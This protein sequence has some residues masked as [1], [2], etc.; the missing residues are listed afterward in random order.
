MT[1]L[2]YKERARLRREQD[3]LKTAARM[4]RDHG[5][6]NLNMDELAEEVG[7]SKPTLY[8][9]FKGKDDMVARTMLQTLRELEA[10][11]GRVPGGHAIDKLDAVMR[12]MMASHTDPE[13]LSIAIVRDGSMMLQHLAH[14]QTEMREIQKRVTDR[15]YALID[16]AKADGHIRPEMSNVIVVGVMFASLSILRGPEI[17]EDFSMSSP[18]LMDHIIGFFRRGVAPSQDDGS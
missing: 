11:L 17:L 4:I 18:D 13:G 6:I 9:H 8:Q 1:K 14:N 15:L 5:Y 12:Y 2:S 3:I 10:Y 16:E 7:I